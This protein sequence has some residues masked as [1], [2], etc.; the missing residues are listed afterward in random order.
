MAQLVLGQMSAG[1]TWRIRFWMRNM[2]TLDVGA[3]S[4]LSGRFRPMVVKRIWRGRLPESGGMALIV[5]AGGPPS[6]QISV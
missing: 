5:A 6:A 4:P 1:G 2:S 3:D